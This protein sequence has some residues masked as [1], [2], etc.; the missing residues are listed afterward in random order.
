MPFLKPSDISHVLVEYKGY[1]SAT[2]HSLALDLCEAVEQAIKNRG[3]EVFG[4]HPRAGTITGIWG[5]RNTEEDTHRAWLIC[6]ERLNGG[7]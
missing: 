1:D 4:Q 5:G 3:W 2:A 7:E 6:P